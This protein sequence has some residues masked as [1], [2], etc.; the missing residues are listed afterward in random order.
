MIHLIRRLRDSA[1]EVRPSDWLLVAVEGLLVFVGIVAAFQLQEW[2]T[3]R[4]EQR[5][6]DRMTHALLGEA[7]TAVALIWNHVDTW[8][9]ALEKAEGV[10][11]TLSA[12]NCPTNEQMADLHMLDFYDTVDPP[13]GVYD[14]LV[15]NAGLSALDEG[16]GRLGLD[17]YYNQRNFY[18][19]ENN[20]FREQAWKLVR[21]DDPAARIVYDAN[22]LLSRR[23]E[24]DMDALCANPEFSDRVNQVVSNQ[25]VFQKLLREPYFTDAAFMC[26]ALAQDLG[27]RC[28][29]AEWF[30]EV[31]GEDNIEMIERVGRERQEQVDL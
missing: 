15:A 8:R 13:T 28:G 12:G 21:E 10:A 5:Q 16:G 30:R 25:A 31:V 18:L 6:I 17:F 4:R 1:R 20:N 7:R 29:D 24:Y 2:A 22:A 27:Q 23:V 14:E 3:D 9:T 26:V 19:N 11:E